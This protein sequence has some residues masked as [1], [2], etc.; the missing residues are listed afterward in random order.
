MLANRGMCSQ[1]LPTGFG[2]LIGMGVWKV[3]AV[4]V[5]SWFGGLDSIMAADSDSLGNPAWAGER[6]ASRHGQ[7]ARADRSR[8]T[9]CRATTDTRPPEFGRFPRMT[10]WHGPCD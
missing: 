8:G 5:Q 9:I 3:E 4:L 1:S 10:A 6:W 7:V 2:R